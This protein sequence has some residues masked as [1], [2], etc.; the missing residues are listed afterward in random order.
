MEIK[1]SDQK[2]GKVILISILVIMIIASIFLFFDSLKMEYKSYNEISTVYEDL[3][4]TESDGDIMIR[5]ETEDGIFRIGNI[6]SNRALYDEI[7]TTFLDGDEITIYY[8]GTNS[9]LGIKK[10][11]N[12]ILDV[13]YSVE[14]LERN[15]RLSLVIFPIILI[16]STVGIVFTY[17]HKKAE[18]ES[19]NPEKTLKI[20]NKYSTKIIKQKVPL[21]LIIIHSFVVL[22]SFLF[23]PYLVK[24]QQ[25]F[26]I[27]IIGILILFNTYRFVA[28]FLRKIE[29]NEFEHEIL[30]FTPF[31]KKTNV[32]NIE[33]INTRVVDE[34][35]EGLDRYLVEFK[36]KNKKRLFKFET[37]SDEQSN[38]IKLILDSN[39]KT[40]CEE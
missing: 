26:V 1:N 18:E 14:K 40:N 16:V 33:Y 35:D 24:V 28:L 23:I 21:Y 17:L 22:C 25:P 31:R 32:D 3:S 12:I 2:I 6:I 10:G 20:E 9:V 13:T 19:I 4:K 38:A 36:F 34:G 8:Y 7:E 27:V 37:T 30:L 29:I 15:D 39:Q 5:I 11:E